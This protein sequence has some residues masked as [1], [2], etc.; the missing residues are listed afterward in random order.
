[1]IPYIYDEE[2]RGIV[3]LNIDT[4]DKAELIHVRILQLCSDE[5]NI[6]PVSIEDIFN[7]LTNI[8]D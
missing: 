3:E 7:F 4:M 2:I 6:Y 5:G 1:M 8:G